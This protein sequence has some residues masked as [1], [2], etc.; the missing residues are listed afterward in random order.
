VRATARQISFADWE[1]MR[2]GDQGV[3]LEPL[4]EAIS[5]FLDDQRDVIE[6]IRRDLV[7]GLKQPGS[8]RNGLTATQVL[9]SLVLMRLKN[10]D[11]RELRER[12]ADGLTLR[13]FTDFY[14]APIPKHDAFQRGFIRFVIRRAILTCPCRKLRFEHIDGVGRPGL[15]L[16][17]HGPFSKRYARPARPCAERGACGPHCNIFGRN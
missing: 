17:A 11:Y 1:L 14:C 7:R 2:Q 9:R 4:L 12:I 15:A 13:Q 8:G 6:C 10:W 5:A 3:R 16:K